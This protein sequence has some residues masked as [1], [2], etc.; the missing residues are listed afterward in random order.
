[1]GI[2][3]LIDSYWTTNQKSFLVQI[4]IYKNVIG[5]QIL[6]EDEKR[7]QEETQDWQRSISSIL[8]PGHSEEPS[9]VTKIQSRRL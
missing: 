4:F 3:L 9:D 7:D 8:N 1:M 6:G 5:K 2:W